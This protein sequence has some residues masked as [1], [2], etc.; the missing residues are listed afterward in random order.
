MGFYGKTEM[1]CALKEKIAV[2]WK[3]IGQSKEEAEFWF[4]ASFDA[5]LKS[6]V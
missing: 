6:Y 1:E 5:Q 4:M 2:P 3:Y